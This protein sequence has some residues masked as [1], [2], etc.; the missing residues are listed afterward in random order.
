MRAEECTRLATPSLYT[1]IIADYYMY[2]YT[3]WAMECL[4]SVLAT[5]KSQRWSQRKSD[6]TNSFTSSSLGI[7]LSLDSN[8]SYVHR[9][10]FRP[11]DNLVWMNRF[12]KVA[13]RMTV[14]NN[15][16]RWRM[17]SYEAW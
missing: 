6:A 17:L 14:E 15:E 7:S 3:G 8:E 4:C 9:K 12:S 16:W 2:V 5:L 13:V 10:A 1:L 11:T